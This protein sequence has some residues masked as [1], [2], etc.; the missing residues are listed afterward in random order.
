MKQ[1]KL[2]KKPH[3]HVP[4]TARRWEST[5]RHLLLTQRSPCLGSGRQLLHHDLLHLH[6]KPRS[7][8]DL[9]HPIRGQKGRWERQ[10]S[11]TPSGA[12]LLLRPGTSLATCSF[13]A[14]LVTWPSHPGAGGD[15]Y[16]WGQR[17]LWTTGP[18]TSW[19]RVRGGWIVD[20]IW[21]YTARWNL[22]SYKLHPFYLYLQGLKTGEGR[23]G[24]G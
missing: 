18:P 19:G 10:V 21:Y 9:S 14:R 6:P 11:A 8:P 2:L 16:S 7:I 4:G 1:N 3:S 23:R 15:V 13:P 12:E 22:S 17:H 5:S 24:K 20:K